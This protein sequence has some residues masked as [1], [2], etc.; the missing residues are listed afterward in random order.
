MD[1]VGVA[2]GGTG[3]DG[4]DGA[5][6][7]VVGADEEGLKSGAGTMADLAWVVNWV[8]GLRGDTSSSSEV[9]GLGTL[10]TSF[11]SSLTVFVSPSTLSLRVLI[12][13]SKILT[14]L[15]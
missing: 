9:S 15:F 13:F 8:P 10:S 14:R 5:K 12:L 4:A 7:A 3:A 6:E 2:T 11:F 1:G